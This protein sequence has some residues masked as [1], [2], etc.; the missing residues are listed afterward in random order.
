MRVAD[1]TAAPITLAADEAL[2][3]ELAPLLSALG[4]PPQVTGAASRLC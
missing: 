4:S 1:L 3:G 2:T